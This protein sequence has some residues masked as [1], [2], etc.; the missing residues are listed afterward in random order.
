L[1]S[2]LYLYGIRSIAVV[3]AIIIRISDLDDISV[4]V[5]Y[6]VR[7]PLQVQR[8]A[9]GDHGACPWQEHG[10]I[11]KMAELV[12]TTLDYENYHIFVGTYPND[13]QTQHEVD[14]VQARFSNVHKVGAPTLDQPA[15]R[16]A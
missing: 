5:V 3:L 1:I 8:E 7:R 9:T 13:P 10:V 11:G 14:Q 16:T 12:V 4:D 2:F 6:W 15:R